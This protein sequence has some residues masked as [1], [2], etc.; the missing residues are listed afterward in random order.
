MNGRSGEPDEEGGV[1]AE[2]YGQLTTESAYNECW[3]IKIP[4]KLAQVW[5]NI[6]S[7][8]DIGELVFTKGGTKMEGKRKIAIKPSLTVLVDEDILSKQQPP[9][10]TLGSASQ[11]TAVPTS[12]PFHYSLQAMTKKVPTLHSFT[13]DPSDGSVRIEGHVTRTANLQVEKTDQNYRKMLQDRIMETAVH[14]NRYVRPVEATESVITKQQQQQQQ[15]GLATSGSGSKK[16]FGDAVLKFGQR[17]LE[18]ANNQNNTDPTDLE[19]N[20]KKARQFAPNEPI[21][22]V[23]FALFQVQAQWTVKDLKAAA[24]R[25]GATDMAS[26]RKA[27]ADMRELLREIGIYHRS[28]DYK[29]MWELRPEYQNAS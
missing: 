13:R 8:T 24:I 3:M 9:S 10:Q 6:P 14:S 15:R 17:M 29:N 21:R 1:T 7:G 19:S 4:T 28:G 2:S 5:E 16:G 23:V 25:G 27:E 11:N 18:A 26:N 22:S 20:P 12:V